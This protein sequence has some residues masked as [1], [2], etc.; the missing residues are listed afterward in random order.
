MRWTPT[1]AAALDPGMR[2]PYDGLLTGLGAGEQGRD[3]I[4]IARKVGVL[5][6]YT[7]KAECF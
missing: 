1:R 3:F 2:P 4:A 6:G 5:A 7:K